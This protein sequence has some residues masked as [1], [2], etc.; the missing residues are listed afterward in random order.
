M[1][2]ILLGGMSMHFHQNNLRGD[3]SFIAYKNSTPGRKS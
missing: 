3:V 1:Q 2:Q